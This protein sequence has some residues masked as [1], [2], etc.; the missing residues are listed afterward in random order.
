VGVDEGDVLGQRF[1][2]CGM[3]EQGEA[4]VAEVVLGMGS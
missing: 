3:G 1:S 4:I 2:R